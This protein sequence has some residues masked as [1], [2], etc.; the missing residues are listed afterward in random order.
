VAAVEE[1]GQ[2]AW[3]RAAGP[4]ARRGPKSRQEKKNQSELV[5]PNFK[6]IFREMLVA[7]IIEKFPKN[8]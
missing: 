8:S 4:E 1:L 3:A 5:F 6:R 7:K 2:E